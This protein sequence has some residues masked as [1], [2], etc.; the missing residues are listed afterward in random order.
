MDALTAAAAALAVQ[1]AVALIMAGT[2]YAS[3]G[4]RCTRYWALSGLLSAIGVL[5]VII[6]AGAPRPVLSTAGNSAVIAGM[7]LQWWGVR[8]FYGKRAVRQAG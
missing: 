1:L 6:N 7:V 5:I 8:A 4:E 3:P 2:F